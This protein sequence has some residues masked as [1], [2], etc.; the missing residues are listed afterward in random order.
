M[1][2]AKNP[3]GPWTRTAMKRS[4]HDLSVLF[5]DD[6]KVYVIWGY[7]EINLTQLNDELT[8]VVHVTECVIIERGSVMGEGVHFYKI[9]GKYFITSAWFARRMRM[10]RARSDKPQGPYE[11][12]MAIS[13]DDN[14]GLAE[15]YRLRGCVA[16]PFNVIPPNTND[17]GTLTLRRISARFWLKFFPR[18]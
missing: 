4:F 6:G 11:I 7:Q 9:N 1:F 3:A 8:D 17:G 16:P 2:R 18:Q 10:P 15:G 14:F 12:N 13:T 5:D